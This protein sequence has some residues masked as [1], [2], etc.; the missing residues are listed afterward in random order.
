MI[1]E[2]MCWEPK[3]LLHDFILWPKH[4]TNT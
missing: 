1:Y 3:Y 4:K 2:N